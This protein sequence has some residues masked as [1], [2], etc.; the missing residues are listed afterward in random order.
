VDRHFR[1]A[2][3]AALILA[4]ADPQAV[5][6]L[7]ARLYLSWRDIPSA[8]VM[9]ELLATLTRRHRSW[10]RIGLKAAFRIPHPR[11]LRYVVL[12]Q[13]I[14][15]RLNT[16]SPRVA[17]RTIAI[18]HP[19]LLG[20]FRAGALGTILTPPPLRFGFVGGGR[21]AK[22]FDEF[23]QLARAVQREHPSVTFEVVGSAPPTAPAAESVN[24]VWSHQKLPLVEFVARLRSLSH[25]IWLGHPRHYDLVAS[26][27]L[28][29]AIALELPVVCQ[30]GPFVDH[31]FRRFGDIGS[32]CE[33]L[34]DMAR[35][36]SGLAA[37]FDAARYRQQK[38]ALARAKQ[39]LS[40][41][42]AA[43][44]LAGALG[45]SRS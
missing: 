25:V 15:D 13:N 38:E 1:R 34:E 29:D 41:E 18:D 22:G 6:L 45:A 19:S 32:R 24:L 5:A 23:L 14:L 4:T 10:K 16:V 11:Q 7:K 8:A 3:P 28:A 21:D 35:H 27:S 39:L 30:A 36:V 2:R 40:P 33:T 42:S 20:D 9:H 12:G 31:L 17:A 37:S 43:S 44:L 26:G